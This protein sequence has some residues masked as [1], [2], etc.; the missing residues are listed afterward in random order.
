LAGRISFDL[1]LIANYDVIML[2][3][4][5]KYRTN[6]GVIVAIEIISFL[7]LRKIIPSTGEK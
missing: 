7:F 4:A 1:A 2:A 3:A 5:I 6:A